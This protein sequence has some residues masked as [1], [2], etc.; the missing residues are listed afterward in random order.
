MSPSPAVIEFVLL[1]V[2]S[3]EDSKS[4]VTIALR[5]NDVYVFLD[6]VFKM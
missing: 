4:V 6:L 3:Q 1:L 2:I 5:K